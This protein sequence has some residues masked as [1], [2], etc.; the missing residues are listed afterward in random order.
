MGRVYLCLGQN[1]E[2]PYYFE[3]ARVHIWNIEELCYFL[4]ENI[5]ALEPSLFSEGLTEWIGQQCGL[6]QLASRLE[7]TQKKENTMENFVQELFGYTCYYEKQEVENL[8]K[9]LRANADTDEHR[10]RKSRGDYF[11]ENGSFVRALEEYDELLKKP[12]GA[13][14][15]L[16]AAVWHN[17]GVAQAGMFWFEKAAQSF[18]QAYRISQNQESAR[19]YL[20]AMRM[21]LPAQEYVDFLSQ[22]PDLYQASMGLERQ[23]EQCSTEWMQS[24]VYNRFSEA[25]AKK[26]DGRADEYDRFMQ[27]NI[28]RLQD[29]Y[30]QAAAR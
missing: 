24:E 22:K 5:W 16:L 15:F 14:S 10:R 13:D 28:S 19:Q 6:T 26:E 8:L 25:A 7:L 23:L 20:A 11:L 3:R 12:M 18:G 9:V 17:T 29:E 21:L 1:A 30:R 4:K 27:E 2:V